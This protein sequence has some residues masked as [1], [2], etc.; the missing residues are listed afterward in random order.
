MTFRLPGTEKQINQELQSDYSPISTQ[1][2]KPANNYTVSCYGP[3]PAGLEPA[4]YGLG[5][6]KMEHVPDGFTR[7]LD[8]FGLAEP[9]FGERRRGAG[10]AAA[11]ARCACLGGTD[12]LM[13]N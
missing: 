7:A 4:T 1:P 3:R 13:V 11:V 2:G 12:N 9:L 8:R 6:R 5:G 10:R